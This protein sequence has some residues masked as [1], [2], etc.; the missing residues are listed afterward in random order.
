MRA[1]EGFE[2]L[3]A[4]LSWPT[5]SLTPCTAFCDPIASQKA[6]LNYPANF[7]AFLFLKFSMHEIVNVGN[8]SLWST[9]TINP[10]LLLTHLKTS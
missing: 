6:F 10:P 7:L 3:W 4:L 1:E 2:S 9:E 8:D 5:L